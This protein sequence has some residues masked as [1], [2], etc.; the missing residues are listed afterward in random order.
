METKEL[1]INEQ[2]A[3]V[4]SMVTASRSRFKRI[5][6]TPTLFWG[7]WLLAVSVAVFIV[8]C[9]LHNMRGH[10][11]WLAMIVPGFPLAYALGR[12][13]S[14]K[15]E[16]HS[17]IDSIVA[18][19]WQ[20]AGCAAG[21][22][23]VLGHYAPPVVASVLAVG[24]ALTGSILRLKAISWTALPLALI[25]PLYVYLS[26]Q[27]IGLEFAVLGALPMI[28]LGHWLRASR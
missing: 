17:R 2:L 24:F 7:Y 16:S 19:L 28:V 5:M 25:A 12:K 10:F 13:R 18:A 21:F 6:A 26:T 15:Q 14:K 23:A 9:L 20:W 22:A 11:I 8:T 27:W 1:T 4:D 3:V